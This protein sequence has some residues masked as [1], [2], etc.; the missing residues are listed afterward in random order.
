MSFVFRIIDPD[1]KLSVFDLRLGSSYVALFT[2]G[3][4]GFT[5]T[6]FVAY[7]HNERNTKGNK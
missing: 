3:Q 6:G 7:K 2:S 1:N 4:L 5:E